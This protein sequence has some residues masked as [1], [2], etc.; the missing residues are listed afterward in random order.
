MPIAPTF[1]VLASLL[2]P[3]LKP[4]ILPAV[5]ANLPAPAIPIKG[6]PPVNI[7]AKFNA[8]K[9][10]IGFSF[11]VLVMPLIPLLTPLP[12]DLTRLPKPYICLGCC[13]RDIVI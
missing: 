4:G 3:K 1:N 6:L 5:P 2:L 12:I 10:N 9:A 11:M 7:G 8:A 13:I